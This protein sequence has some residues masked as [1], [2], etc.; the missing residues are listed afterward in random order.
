MTLMY[1]NK[2][3]AIRNISGGNTGVMGMLKG[4]TT[5]ELRVLEKHPDLKN[6]LFELAALTEQEAW[7]VLEKE[8]GLKVAWE[9]SDGAWIS[10][11]ELEERV[12]DAL[13]NPHCGWYVTDK[14]ELLSLSRELLSQEIRI[15]LQ[16][17][18]LLHKQG[19]SAV[20]QE[21]LYLSGFYL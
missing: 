16:V 15:N 1:L 4:F 6:K 19:N 11:E 20:P 7:G 12:P 2:E 8:Y 17:R 14:A 3:A 18:Y 5:H 13:R 9:S 21:D 10:V